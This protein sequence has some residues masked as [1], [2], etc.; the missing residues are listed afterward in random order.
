MISIVIPSYE[1]KINEF[2]QAVNSALKSKTNEII[3]VDDNSNPNLKDYFEYLDELKSNPRIKIIYNNKNKG[4]F[5]NS[6]FSL[7]QSTN[8]FVK[9]LDV[10]DEI[11]PINFDKLIDKANDE[12]LIITR[13]SFKKRL[14]NK[15]NVKKWNL[16]NG[17]CIYKTENLKDLKI[18]NGPVNFFGDIIFIMDILSLPDVKVLNI[19]LDAY[20]YKV[21]SS[22][23]PKQLLKKSNDWFKGYRWIKE[24]ADINVYS[25]FTIEKLD[26]FNELMNLKLGSNYQKVKYKTFWIFNFL[27]KWFKKIISKTV[28]KF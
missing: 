11:K 12:D 8:R 21:I 18:K 14:K 24:N 25:A 20:K 7:Q 1:P 17:S 6:L 10:D 26:L 28:F 19:K 27:P 15:N 3:I 5:N 23:K 22:T 9:K 16:F 2:K 13:Y 4:R